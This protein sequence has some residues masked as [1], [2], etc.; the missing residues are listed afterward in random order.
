MQR[1]VVWRG[2]AAECCGVDPKA[3]GRFRLHQLVRRT[4]CTCARVC[5]GMHVCWHIVCVRVD[6]GSPV[7][8]VCVCFARVDVAHKDPISLSSAA[9]A[10]MC[11]R[12]VLRRGPR[13]CS[14]GHALQA[15]LCVLAP[16][17]AERLP[18]PTGP[19]EAGGF[20]R[21]QRC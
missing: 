11:A 12:C 6:V 7:N 5:A 10:L 9:P 4:V 8:V 19:R 2:V 17:A 13:P 16:A 18:C 3:T 15:A 21:S 14:C 20:G 1:G